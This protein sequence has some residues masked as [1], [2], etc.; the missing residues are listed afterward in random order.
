MARRLVWLL[1]IAG[2][3]ACAP[4]SAPAGRS[5]GRAAASSAPAPAVHVPPPA[6]GA[7]AAAAS[8]PGP[9]DG[10]GGRAL[11][12][13]VLEQGGSQV[14]DVGAERVEPRWVDLHPT[15]GFVPLIGRGAVLAAAERLRG[16]VVVARGEVARGRPDALP[17][18]TERCELPM[19]M[20]SD[21]VQTPAGARP[22][23]GAAPIP[24][25]RASGVEPFEGL[26]A[27][28]RGDAGAAD[29]LE[30]RL[31]NR[32][33]RPL[34]GPVIVRV[35]YEGCHGKPGTFA[36]ERRFDAGLAPGGRLTATVP[37]TEERS[38]RGKHA[39]TSVEVVASGRDVWFDMDVAL[40]RL[41]VDVT[42]GGA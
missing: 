35:H 11:L 30:V 12:V 34:V 28:L 41:G 20:R 2:V 10:D 37:A 5:P 25:L 7:A 23:R 38:G 1:G 6:S 3:C 14:C 32:L 9:S 15:V 4:A 18:G 16:R 40:S 29:A 21:W 19:Q 39:A 8:S 24:A 33:G 26:T 22:R 17:P 42:C 36:V 27:T 31:D 13:G